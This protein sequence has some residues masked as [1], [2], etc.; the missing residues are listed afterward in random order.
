MSDAL[1]SRPGQ[2]KRPKQ[3]SIG[4]TRP[5][6]WETLTTTF[7]LKSH[8]NLKLPLS[9]GTGINL[10]PSSSWISK[11]TPKVSWWLFRFTTSGFRIGIRFHYDFAVVKITFK[12]KKMKNQALKEA[13]TEASILSAA[14]GIKHFNVWHRYNVSPSLFSVK[15]NRPWCWWCVTN[16]IIRNKWNEATTDNE[17]GS[18]NLRTPSAVVGMERVTFMPAVW[19]V[20]SSTLN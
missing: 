11:L 1:A 19:I 2:S 7:L 14:S 9:K 20:S 13:Q 17:P 18:S 15:A 6:V 10:A 8:L 12:N 3:R 16:C 5:L 4:S